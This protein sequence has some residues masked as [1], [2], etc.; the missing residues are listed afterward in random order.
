MYNLKG[1][2]RKATSNIQVEF[3][4]LAYATQNFA[5]VNT[6]GYKAVRFEDVIDADGSVHGVERVDTRV[7]EYL[8]TNK[9]GS[10][11]FDREFDF[12]DNMIMKL[13]DIIY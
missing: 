12:Y 5:N 4:R 1:I 8:I 9:I 2:V 10:I 7:G 11:S 13:I 3:D 6:N